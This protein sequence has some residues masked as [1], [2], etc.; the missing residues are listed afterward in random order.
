MNIYVS[1]IAK[2]IDVLENHFEV[3]SSKDIDRIIGL[4]NTYSYT[5]FDKDKDG[6]PYMEK[7]FESYIE[8]ACN[9]SKS[10]S[11]DF[12]SFI[13]DWLIYQKKGEFIITKYKEI[14]NI[15]L[16]K[17]KDIKKLP[18]YKEYLS[19]FNTKELK[20]QTPSAFKPKKFDWDLFISLIFGSFSVYPELHFYKDGT[21][22]PRIILD[23]DKPGSYIDD[24]FSLQIRELAY[25]FVEEQLRLDIVSYIDEDEKESLELGRIKCLSRFDEELDKYRR[26]KMY[27]T[28]YS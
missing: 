6:L 16:K 3:K 4:L 27:H 7:A 13:H 11:F 12:H 2:L 10:L 17:V 26:Y 15:D 23:K 28:L 1:N 25:I 5:Y 19:H 21:Y 9:M 22:I 14:Y 24:M 18:I 20:F 8:E